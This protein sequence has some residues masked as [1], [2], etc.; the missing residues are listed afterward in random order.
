MKEK[1]KRVLIVFI[2]LC[3]GPYNCYFFYKGFGPHNLIY[4]DFSRLKINTQM[5]KNY[6]GT[7]IKTKIL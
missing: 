3:F 6:I 2:L 4:F 7:Y 5:V 1:Y